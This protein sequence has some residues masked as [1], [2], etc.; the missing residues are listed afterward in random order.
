MSKD[1]GEIKWKRQAVFEI[2]TV[3]YNRQ[4]GRKIE[5]SQMGETIFLKKRYVLHTQE[6][7]F[8]VPLISDTRQVELSLWMLDE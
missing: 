4:N 2:N 7:E 8:I 3:I 5:K 1:L 6:M